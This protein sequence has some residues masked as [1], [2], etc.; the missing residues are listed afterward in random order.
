MNFILPFPLKKFTHLVN[1]KQAIILIGSCFAEEIGAKLE[2]RKF[3][4][5]INPHGI[6]YNPISISSALTDYISQKKYT[7]RDIFLHD[8]LWRSFN[9]HG[10][11]ANKDANICL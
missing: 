4:A 9:H 5:L 3:N 6:L 10:K 7:Q 2:E 1:I 8:G 11:F